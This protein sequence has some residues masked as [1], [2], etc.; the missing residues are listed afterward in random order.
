MA[1]GHSHNMQTMQSMQASVPS[2]A[3]RSNSSTSLAKFYQEHNDNF[4]GTGT[5]GGGEPQ[6]LDYCNAFWGANDAGYE[7]LMAR[8]RASGRTTED[9]KAFWKER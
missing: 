7:V 9:L 6:D 1:P 5:A 2:F 3:R 4:Y 8:L